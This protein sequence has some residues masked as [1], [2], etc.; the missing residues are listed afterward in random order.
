MTELEKAYK[1]LVQA[2]AAEDVF[3]NL[4][5]MSVME[6]FDEVKKVFFRLEQIVSPAAN[7]GNPTSEHMAFEAFR[8]LL[9]LRDEANTKI[10]CCKY[11]VEGETSPIRAAKPEYT[12][13]VGGIG[14]KLYPD[15]T[16]YDGFLAYDADRQVTDRKS[17]KII[18]LAANSVDDNPELENMA[19]VLDNV[20]HKSLPV[21]L[22]KFLLDDD[23]TCLVLQEI[24]DAY[25]LCTVREKFPDGL[26]QEHTVWIL[27]RLLS[28]VGFMHT[29]LVVHAGI[30]P[31]TVLITPYNHNAIPFDLTDAIM[32]ANLEHAVYSSQHAYSAPEV[33]PDASPHPAA[34]MYSIGLTMLYLLGGDIKTKLFP[35]G[36]D[37]KIKNFLEG[38]LLDD[39]H[40]RTDDAWKAHGKL[41]K[42]RTEVFGAPNQFLKL[43]L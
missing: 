30:S 21:L 15:A 22:D 3:G 38:F 27:D 12:F 5:G 32:D 4:S 20:S 29:K 23:R 10:R 25:D 31:E 7:K 19:R 24:K 42:I 41:K 13:S 1:L 17:E 26:P 11:G 43:K 2:N 37:P 39:P 14:Y 33:G 16:E 35:S 9:R 18:L 6:A 36:I 34:D 40:R 8:E 28:V